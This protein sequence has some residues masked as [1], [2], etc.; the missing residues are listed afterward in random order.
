MAIWPVTEKLI[1]VA[2]YTNTY[3]VVCTFVQRI[4]TGCDGA[5]CREADLLLCPSLAVI[6]DAVVFSHISWIHGPDRQH[7]AALVAAAALESRDIVS[8]G[9]R[10][11]SWIRQCCKLGHV[12]LCYQSLD[13]LIK[14]MSAQNIPY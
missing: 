13:D 2:P 5:R 14:I 1:V 12:S 6:R 9:T 3:N 7:H 8:E 4:V 11:T 10:L